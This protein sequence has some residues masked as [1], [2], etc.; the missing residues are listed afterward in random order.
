M[1]NTLTITNWIDQSC[2][3]PSDRTRYKA[4]FAEDEI[5]DALN[6]MKLL[7][8]KTITEYEK[9][10]ESA[11]QALC[12]LSGWWNTD[13]VSPISSKIVTAVARYK[14][15]AETVTRKDA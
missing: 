2:E 13:L 9:G 1:K 6:E 10:G 4:T 15:L 5:V 14:A 3:W 11:W 7:I 8:D 12:S